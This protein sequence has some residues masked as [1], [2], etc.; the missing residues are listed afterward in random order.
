MFT[1]WL[2]SFST[3]LY[4]FVA[5]ISLIKGKAQSSLSLYKIVHAQSY[6]CPSAIR[7]RTSKLEIREHKIQ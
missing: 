1:F 5:Q 2:V 3:I 4:A 7:Q 6:D